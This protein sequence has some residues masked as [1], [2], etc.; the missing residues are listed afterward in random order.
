M[1]QLNENYLLYP[2]PNVSLGGQKTLIFV[3]FRL[4]M[5]EQKSEA[6]ADILDVWDEVWTDGTPGTESG[7]KL[8][9]KEIVALL[10]SALESQ[11]WKMKAQAAKAMGAIGK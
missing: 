1:G 9:M 2:C 4:A 10:T 11:Q 5:H 8:Y 3:Y 6:N 7:I